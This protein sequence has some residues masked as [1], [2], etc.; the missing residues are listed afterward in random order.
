MKKHF[1]ASLPLFIYECVR[2]ILLSEMLASFIFS[3]TAA[4][5]A[6]LVFVGTAAS[7][8]F[9]LLVFFLWLD[10]ER[11]AAFK[12]LYI[13]GKASASLFAI[14]ALLFFVIRESPVTLSSVLASLAGPEQN[15][16]FLAL[17]TA[18]F[19]VFDLLFT[20]LAIAALRRTSDVPE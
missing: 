3:N 6:V 11:Y 14:A 18:F 13:A 7:A 8:L 12:V 10:V 5:N 16:Y 4:Q 1:P 20:V 2:L 9:P 15:A 19:A 17:F